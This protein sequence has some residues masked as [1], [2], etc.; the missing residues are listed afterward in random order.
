[1]VELYLADNPSVYDSKRTCEQEVRF[2]T[3]PKNGK[4]LSK[5]DYDNVVEH[6]YSAGYSSEILKDLVFFV[7]KM[8]I[9]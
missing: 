8:R 9:S 3:N 5:I 7:Y 2:G 1:M 4:P 6:F